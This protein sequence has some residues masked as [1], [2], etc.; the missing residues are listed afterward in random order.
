MTRG[1]FTRVLGNLQDI[2]DGKVAPKGGLSTL[3]G[4]ATRMNYQLGDLDTLNVLG[5]G[6][7]GK[8]NLVKAKGTGEFYA[9]K[10]QGKQFILDSGQQEYI[11]NEFR[12]MQELQHP[13]VL[14]MHCAMQDARYI[15]FLLDL[16]PGGE[17]MDILETKGNFS[18]EWV[19]FYSASVLLAYTEFHKHRVVYRDLKPENLV[20]DRNG[21]CVVV[22]LGLAKKLKDGPTYT[23]CGTPDYIAPEIIRGTGYSWAVDYWALGVFLYE[24]HSGRAPFQSYDPTGTAK[25]ILAAR[26][27]FPSKFSST[28]QSVIKALLN[29]DPTRRLGCMNDGTDGVMRHR[30]YTGF[31][32]Q[33]LLDKAIKPPYTP[34]IPA[35]L[36]KIGK[37]DVAKGNAKESKWSPVLQ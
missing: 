9:L 24:L 4:Q 5:Q 29:K 6:A 30:F 25:K 17:L 21:Y 32:W 16:L 22:D 26:I 13:N 1:D 3:A 31:D 28:T 18:E 35:N 2:I 19:R 37:R 14:I 12:L 8:V 33:G 10:A 36:E 34:K 11:L 27:T 20:L 15:Y 23:F 7:F